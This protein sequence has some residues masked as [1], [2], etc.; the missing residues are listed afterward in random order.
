M[1]SPDIGPEVQTIEDSL[2]IS[3]PGIIHSVD[4]S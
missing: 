1:R 4:E 3:R 2:S